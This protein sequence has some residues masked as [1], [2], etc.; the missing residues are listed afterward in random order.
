MGL[1]RHKDSKKDTVLKE[2]VRDDD[3]TVYTTYD[4]VAIS[5]FRKERADAGQGNMQSQKFIGMNYY[6]GQLVEKDYEKAAYWL[7]KAAEQDDADSQYLVGKMYEYGEGVEQSYIQ[8]RIWM[9]RAA[10][11]NHKGARTRLP[12]I[13]ELAE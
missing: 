13:R 1:F 6:L 7:T 2:P 5:T 9:E 8:A 10:F 4:P 12:K 3:D 11:R